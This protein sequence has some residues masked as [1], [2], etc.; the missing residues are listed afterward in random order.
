[1]LGMCSSISTRYWFHFVYSF[2]TSRD[3]QNW[4]PFPWH[5]TRKGCVLGAMLKW[6]L[7]FPELVPLQ[8]KS[9]S[10][11]SSFFPFKKVLHCIFVKLITGYVVFPFLV[12]GYS[13]ISSVKTPGFLWNGNIQIVINSAIFSLIFVVTLTLFKLGLIQGRNLIH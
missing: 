11:I 13:S 2:C 9:D 8:C 3:Q 5:H 12:F 4:M 7:T 6:I 10:K 1:M